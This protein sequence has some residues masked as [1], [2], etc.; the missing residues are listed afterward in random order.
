MV[1][2]DK[3]VIANADIRAFFHDS[4]GAAL[5]N[6]RIEAEDHTIHYIV[7]LLSGFTR[8]E[9]LYPSASGAAR[10]PLA[11]MLAQALES[12][13]AHKR[14]E[15]LRQLGDL[16]L[17]ISGFFPNSLSRSLVD[18]DYYIAMGGNAYGSLSDSVKSYSRGNVFSAVFAELAEKFQHFA[19]V[20]SEV[21]EQALLDSDRDVLRLYERW[22]C[23]RSKRIEKQ[24]RK[25]GIHPLQVALNPA[26]H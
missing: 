11:L 16:A 24:L 5:I 14:N 15:A 13:S 10:K 12:S 21:S 19:D 6:Q 26:R 23:T 2:D 25:L 18:V 8:T 4:V 7:D 20:L 3:Q 9:N 22:V 1:A 17:F